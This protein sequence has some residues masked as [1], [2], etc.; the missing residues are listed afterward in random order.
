MQPSWPPIPS[1]AFN[2]PDMV[3]EPMRRR[4]GPSDVS[5]GFLSLTT[6]SLEAFSSVLQTVFNETHMSSMRTMLLGAQLRSRVIRSR[7]RMLRAVSIAGHTQADH[8][9]GV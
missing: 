6:Q 3:T 7:S 1:R 8:L 4:L 2:S 5:P 9:L